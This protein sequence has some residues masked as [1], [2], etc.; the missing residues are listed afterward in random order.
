MGRGAV[1]ETLVRQK[2]ETILIQTENQ[3]TEQSTGYFDRETAGEKVSE[4]AV[5]KGGPPLPVPEAPAKKRLSHSSKSGTRRELVQEQKEEQGQEEREHQS[6]R[7][8]SLQRG[9]AGGGDSTPGQTTQNQ[10]Q[11]KRV[12]ELTE[13]ERTN[14]YSD[15]QRKGFKQN[16]LDI[17]K[18]DRNAGFS[19]AFQNLSRQIEE[20]AKLDVTGD[21]YKTDR[22]E[23]VFKERELLGQ[24]LSELD[25]QVQDMKK[26]AKKEEKKDT[27]EGKMLR[28]EWEVLSLYKGYFDLDT[29]GYL[30]IP[31]GEPKERIH[32]CQN[33]KMKMKGKTLSM[34]KV[35]IKEPLFP[36]EPSINDIAQ[37]RVGDCYLLSALSALVDKSPQWIKDCMKDNGDGSVTVRLY[38]WR[39]KN[40]QGRWVQGPVVPHYITVSKRVPGEYEEQ[41]EPF[42]KG[43]LWVQMIEKA[44]TLSGFHDE[45]KPADDYSSIAGGFSSVF[46]RR[47]TG[48]EKEDIG[49]DI[50]SDRQAEDLAMAMVDY[51]RKQI[52][53]T[54]EGRQPRMIEI[55]KSMLGIT[56][57]TKEEERLLIKAM[58]TYFETFSGMNIYAGTV[59]DAQAFLNS[60]TVE[61]YR[62]KQLERQRE[63]IRQLEAEAAAYPQN[64]QKQT[65]ELQAAKPAIDGARSI[66][67]A[68]EKQ[69]ADLEKQRDDR[70]LSKREAKRL[71]NV[72]K[73]LEDERIKT[74]IVVKPERQ[75]RDLVQ[76]HEESQKKLAEMKI[77]EA[78]LA[79]LKENG[80]KEAEGKAE[81]DELDQILRYEEQHFLAIK[82]FY[83]EHGKDVLE[84]A[85]FSGKYTERAISVYDQIEEAGR[86]GKFQTASTR[87]NFLLSREGGLNGE[88]LEDGLASS[89]AYT[90]MGVKQIGS[91]RYV[92]LRNPWSRVVRAYREGEGG[93]VERMEEG[94]GNHGIFLLELNEFMTRYDQFGAVG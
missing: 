35:P 42:A 54:S 5:S 45:T 19:K 31:E 16:L 77:K 3:Q 73:K 44:Y 21:L 88:G 75:L 78:R 17:V 71:E 27:Q 28:R 14:T 65:L 4:K 23:L 18:A 47:I 12:G 58:G 53:A 64:L 34:K 9:Y 43:A 40:P 59:E 83:E 52:G 48:Q 57:S 24:I 89:H 49:L 70:G 39:E 82:Q 80:W 20:Y 84:H 60:L 55:Q 68:L 67:A 26:K 51:Q 63:R 94:D 79:G 1:G 29:S 46:L 32:D 50:S 10:R 66:V 25:R 36:H 37:G 87:N 86:Q 93:K 62:E 22:K 91:Y 76:K 85:S 81:P 7:E 74:S 90:L 30:K 38:D 41:K 69:K 15:I 13:E 92:K 11:G 72:K 8:Q 56:E 61:Q 2:Q 33:A 6:R